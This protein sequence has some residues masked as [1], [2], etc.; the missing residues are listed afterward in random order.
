MKSWIR[1]AAISGVPTVF[2]RMRARRGEPLAQLLTDPHA[3]E[4]P[5]PFGAR[6]RAEGRLVRTPFLLASADH[7]VCRN[8]LRDKNFGVTPPDAMDLPEPFRRLIRATD[9]RLASPVEPPSMLMVDPPEHTRYRKLVA[10]AFTPRAVARLCDRVGEVTEELLDGLAARENADLIGDFALLLPI[11]IISEILGIPADKRDDMLEF[12][13]AGSPLLDITVSWRQ[14]RAAVAALR[15]SQD[16]LIGHIEHL[17]RAPGDNILSDLATGG[18]LTDRELLATA[19]L[20]AGAGFETT[21]NL[22]GN[23]TMLLRD[24]PD[25]LDLLRAE[26]ARW[27]GAIEEMLRYDS[28]VQMTARTALRDTEIAGVRIRAGETI[29][30]LLGSANRDPAV[31]LDPDTFDIT[32]SNAKDH[33]AFGSGVHACLGASLARMEGAI[34]LR[35]LY[36]RFPDLR[37]TGPATRRGLVNLRGYEHIPVSTG[38][39]RRVVVG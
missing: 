19:T 3:R 4:N 30:L 2:L 22:L 36:D 18:Q 7:E 24:H 32:R 21:V 6:I 12:G 35:A 28:P 9:L 14:F 39:E 27:P 8:I 29:A 1:W 34:A 33:L 16:Y 20:V 5:Y 11:A 38:V 26:P 31:F 13:N 10:G 25:Q 17:R 23:G 37:H 15:A